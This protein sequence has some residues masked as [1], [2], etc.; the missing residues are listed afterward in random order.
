M[1]KSKKL[2][3]NI[4]YKIKYN[5]SPINKEK[6]I[7][8]REKNEQTN[9]KKIKKSINSTIRESAYTGKEDLIHFA[10]DKAFGCIRYCLISH[11]KKQTTLTKE[12]FYFLINY[13]AK[14]G[15]KITYAKRSGRVDDNYCK[16]EVKIK[17]NVL[18]NVK[19]LEPISPDGCNFYIEW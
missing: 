12:H 10:C 11:G 6:A 7:Q 5:G 14:K 19:T 8:L 9:L 2:I 13:Y 15:F 18:F 4:Q 1:N 3:D 16:K 17:D